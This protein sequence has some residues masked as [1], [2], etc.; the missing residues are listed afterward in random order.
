M[1]TT[2]FP[3]TPA[4]D[5]S[6]MGSV[7]LNNISI[8]SN[9]SNIAVYIGP[10]NDYCYFYTSRSSSSWITVNYS[11]SGNMIANVAFRTT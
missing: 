11:S 2:G 9:V 5:C 3:Y 8:H 10:A 1:R 6:G 7:M 4:T